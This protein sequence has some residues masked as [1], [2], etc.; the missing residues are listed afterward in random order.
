MEI[1]ATTR[2]DSTFI[3][4]G[5]LILKPAI[6]W[7]LAQLQDMAS[8]RHPISGNIN[9]FANE[10][11]VVYLFAPIQSFARIQKVTST[12]EGSD[13]YIKDRRLHFNNSF[14]SHT[15]IGAIH[16]DYIAFTDSIP[17]AVEYRFS[18]NDS[19]LETKYKYFSLGGPIGYLG[20]KSGNFF[21]EVGWEFAFNPYILI[22][23]LPSINYSIY[24]HYSCWNYGLRLLFTG[25]SAGILY[26][27]KKKLD[28]SFGLSL[29]VL[30]VEFRSKAILLQLS[31]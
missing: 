16:K 11:S 8:I 3:I 23:V 6:N 20:K 1:E 31:I 25:Y 15:F 10:Y 4:S 5:N 21:S 13:I 19:S 28:Y 12:F 22:S 14:Q 9:H 27:E 17:E 26:N 24:S 29:G 30:G 18:K 7:G 2:A